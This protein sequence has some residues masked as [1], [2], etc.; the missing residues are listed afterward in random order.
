LCGRVRAPHVFPAS[1]D[2]SHALAIKRYT[3]G[4][5]QL[6]AQ[7]KEL[8]MVNSIALAL[9]IFLVFAN[10]AKAH[11]AE[12]LVKIL[13]GHPV[14]LRVVPLLIAQEQRF[15][16]K[17]SIDPLLVTFARPGPT[18]IASLV[19]EE[20][21]IAYVSA[22]PIIGAAAQGMDLKMLASFSA[23]RLY[24]KLVA[25]PDIKRPEELRG[26]RIGVP[27]IGGGI[28]MATMLASEQMGLNPQRDNIKILAV[29]DQASMPSA[30]EAGAID[31]AIFDPGLAS[32]L[33]AKGFSIVADLS[34][35]NIPPIGIGPVVTSAYLRRYPEVVE[36]VMTALVES[37]AFSLS[38]R[39]KSTVL[40][41]LMKHLRI[42]DQAAAEES[43]QE[44]LLF[45][46]K[47]YPPIKGM[48]D[49]QRLLAL[50]NPKVGNVKIEEI[51]ESR[52]VRKLDDSGFI[53]RLYM[54]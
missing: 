14:S 34:R 26:K 12:A 43:Y 5:V 30:L 11:S 29:G 48:R 42:T 31:G 44:L 33:E 50:Q 13:I 23:D 28:W 2:C 54:H 21:Q 22:P 47:P 32:Q 40:K 45:N 6:R 16:A 10:T 4:Q 27:N 24:F 37:L 3:L 46:R 17:H 36:K 9:A 20:L 7:T 8:A 53:D 35:F 49:V 15:F 1:L 38:S 51:V 18:I 19:A 41:T 39:N 52:F 25:R